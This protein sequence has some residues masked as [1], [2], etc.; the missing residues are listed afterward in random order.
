[1]AAR[2]HYAWPIVNESPTGVRESAACF[3][4]SPSFSSFRLSGRYQA[5]PISEPQ[6]CCPKRVSTPRSTT[7]STRSPPSPCRCRRRQRIR[8][9]AS[10]TGGSPTRE[11]ATEGDRRAGDQSKS[12]VEPFLAAVARSHGAHHRSLRGVDSPLRLRY[13]APVTTE[14]RCSEG[15]VFR[16]CRA[17]RAVFFCFGCPPRENTRPQLVVAVIGASRLRFRSSST[18]RSSPRT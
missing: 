17:P 5:R 12:T 4:Y 13:E 10:T 15:T 7:C 1:M 16:G 14:I 11:V 9:Y 18:G 2:K 6:P 8:T 3:S